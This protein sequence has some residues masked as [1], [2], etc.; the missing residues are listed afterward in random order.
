MCSCVGLDSKDDHRL[1]VGRMVKDT[2]SVQA[3]LSGKGDAGTIQLPSVP[4]HKENRYK[5]LAIVLANG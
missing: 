2:Y 4:K 1:I 5:L 3:I